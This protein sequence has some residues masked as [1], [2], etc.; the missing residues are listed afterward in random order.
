MWM[1]WMEDWKDGRLGGDEVCGFGINGLAL[2][3]EMIFHSA[4]WE[5]S[6]I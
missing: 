5:T 2:P 4:A 6:L 1:G 3:E